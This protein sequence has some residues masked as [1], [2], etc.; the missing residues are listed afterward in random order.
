[1]TDTIYTELV[2]KRYHKLTVLEL[3]HRDHQRQWWVRCECECGAIVKKRAHAVKHGQSKGCGNCRFES[4]KRTDAHNR[5]SAVM[6][7]NVQKRRDAW[8]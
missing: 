8:R 4:K 2:G 6:F 7:D 5:W 1:M 3:L